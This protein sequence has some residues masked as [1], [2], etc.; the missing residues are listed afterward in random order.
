LRAFAPIHATLTF[1]GFAKRWVR[2]LALLHR[3]IQLSLPPRVREDRFSGVSEKLFSITDEISGA[4]RL[5]SIEIGGSAAQHADH[6][7]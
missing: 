5:Y 1:L 4:Y 2:P 3:I 7:L 6:L